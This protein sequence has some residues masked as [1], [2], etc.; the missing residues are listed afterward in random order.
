MRQFLN[1]PYGVTFVQGMDRALQISEQHKDIAGRL[2][3]LKEK[4]ADPAMKEQLMKT[5]SFV[6]VGSYCIRLRA[7]KA[8]AL[9][10]AGG[11]KEISEAQ[12][13]HK[14]V[15]KIIDEVLHTLANRF[16]DLIFKALDSHMEKAL[17][18]YS[19]SRG[20]LC[21]AGNNLKGDQ[22][23]DMRAVLTALQKSL[24]DFMELLK[25][26]FNA[27]ALKISQV[28]GEGAAQS[29]VLT[30]R[31]L[32][33]W[34]QRLKDCGVMLLHPELDLAISADEVSEAGCL[35]KEH[36]D[37]VLGLLQCGS[38]QSE[39]S[40]ASPIWADIV[41]LALKPGFTAKLQRL[42][43]QVTKAKAC[44]CMLSAW[45]RFFELTEQTTL[46]QLLTMP[47]T[48]PSKK[49]DLMDLTQSQVGDVRDKALE[50]F[51]A[52]DGTEL[53]E[54]LMSVNHGKTVKV[55]IVNIPSAVEFLCVLRACFNIE[56]VQKS[57]ETREENDY[58]SWWSS[59]LTLIS[60]ACNDLSAAIAAL[61]QSVVDLEK[62]E[63]THQPPICFCL[64]ANKINK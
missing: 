51:S 56:K 30:V 21:S 24:A 52:A 1:L 7:E 42:H 2:D 39:G 47:A 19:T 35:I 10:V 48:G 25:N 12:E 37:G 16:F 13:V 53:D 63:S 15:L 40:T 5:S 6:Q 22:H 44:P 26:N 27:Q 50:Y 38:R 49:K 59:S 64:N 9:A 36:N 4:V 11:Q 17:K 28:E 45:S 57:L 18:P 3:K 62:E 46:T 34:A 20:K 29:W 23:D 61:E 55:S 60:A 41:R 14:V 8:Q 58:V 31:K 33:L 32:S 43:Q 54:S